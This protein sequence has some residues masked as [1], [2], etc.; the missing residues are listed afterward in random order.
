MNTGVAEGVAARIVA[1]DLAVVAGVVVVV[2]A[3]NRAV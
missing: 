1:A 3:A 2:V